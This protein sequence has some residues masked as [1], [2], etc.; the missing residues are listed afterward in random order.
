MGAGASVPDSL[1]KAAAKG[2]AGDKW[3][4]DITTPHSFAF[5][6][7]QDLFPEERAMLASGQ[8]R[9]FADEHGD[10]FVLTK[11]YMHSKVLSQPPLL[12]FPKAF[13]NR[14]SSQ[15]GPSTLLERLEVSDDRAKQLRKRRRLLSGE[16]AVSHVGNDALDLYCVAAAEY[17]DWLLAPAPQPAP[18]PSTVLTEQRCLGSTVGEPSSNRESPHLPNAAWELQ[19]AYERGA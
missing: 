10:V 8:S 5:K 14:L 11:T 19:I 12:C 18:L 6:R 4:E 3:N 13:V 2:L 7:R 15:G 17:Y 16:R 9:D 1:D